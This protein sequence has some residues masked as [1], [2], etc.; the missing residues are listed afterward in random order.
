MLLAENNI[1]LAFADKLNEILPCIFPDSKIAKEYKM[2]KTKAS[3]ILNE[4][5]ALHFLQQ[6]VG[7]MK[8]D[9]YSLSTDGSKDTGLD[10]INPLTVCLFNINTSIVYSRFLDMYCTTSGKATTIF[11][12]IDDVITKIQLPWSNCVGFHLI[13]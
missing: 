10:K 6:T 9:F 2:G 7:I 11:Q 4:S 13:T 12:K 3:C 8:T 1:P 5:L